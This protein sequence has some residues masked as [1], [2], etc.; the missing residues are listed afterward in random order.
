MH[1]RPVGLLV[2]ALMITAV[3]TPLVASGEPT[4]QRL[5]VGFAA[6]HAPASGSDLHGAKVLSVDAE[7]GVTIVEAKNRAV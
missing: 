2:A 5:A 7:L 4:P 3:A 6:E 1:A